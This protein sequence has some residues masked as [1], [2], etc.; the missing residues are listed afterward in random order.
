MQFT[1][2]SS[3]SEKKIT[4]RLID[5][6]AAVKFIKQYFALS[7]SFFLDTGAFDLSSALIYKTKTMALQPVK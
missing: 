6:I 1:R 7:Y 3:I 4:K 2:F 5:L